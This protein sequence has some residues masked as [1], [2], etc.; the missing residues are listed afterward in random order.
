MTRN[1]PIADSEMRRRDRAARRVEPMKIAEHEE[2]HHLSQAI[3]RQVEACVELDLSRDALRRLA[4]RASTLADDL[5]SAALGKP[6]S[7]VESGWDGDGTG[8]MN[9]LPFSPIMGRL[10]PASYGLGIH[11]SD[12]RAIGEVTFSET[13][14]GAEGLVHGGVI[15]GIWDE[16]LAAA[17]AIHRTGGP[18]G[19]LTVRYLKPTFL[20]EPLRFVA[21]VERIDERKI[22]VKGECT[23]RDQVLS[24]AEGIFIRM[25]RPGIDWHKAERSEDAR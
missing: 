21:W 1:A 8:S 2:W 23:S 4:D 9:Y 6:F 10:N 22:I 25:R 5:E 16:V 17:N 24:E 15:S 3:R 18:T 12:D 14:E 11:Q 19:S 7:L 20:H 13:A